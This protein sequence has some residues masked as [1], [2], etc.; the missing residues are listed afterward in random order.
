M[1]DDFVK[2]AKMG[3]AYW[4]LGAPLSYLTATG[5]VAVRWGIFEMA[6]VGFIKILSRKPELAE[7]GSKP[8]GNFDGKAK[9]FRKLARLAFSDHP[10]IAEKLCDYSTRANQT[11]K[12]RNAIIHGFWFDHQ[13]FN[14]KLGVTLST[15]ADGSGD[16]YSV[17]LSQLETLSTKIAGLHLEGILMLFPHPSDQPNEFLTPDE[18]SALQE[19]HKNFPA[20]HQ[21]VP[22][23]RDPNRK[24]LPMQ[25]E[26]FQA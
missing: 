12:K 5:A 14:S 18:L 16:F 17:E 2:L 25:P 6:F 21:E 23:P 19:Y 22:T 15:E 11:C 26:P 7:L 10:K 4:N 8:P 20:P 1:E 24:G 3:K 13:H 9:L